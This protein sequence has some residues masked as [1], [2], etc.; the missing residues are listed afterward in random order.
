MCSRCMIFLIANAAVMFTACPELCPS[1][2]PGAPCTSG[3]V[4]R[5]ARNL[6]RLRNAIEVGAERD[7]GFAGAPSRN[8]GRGNSRHTLAH[9][10][11]VLLEDADDVLRRFE[12][13]KAQL[14][15]AE[16]LIDELLRELRARV[17][18]A[19][20]LGLERSELRAGVG[21]RAL[22]ARA[23]RHHEQQRKTGQTFG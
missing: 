21:R 15:E 22:R 13:L 5:D 7:D 18:V 9:R 4:A 10:E 19:H 1:P 20:R 12:F 6:R 14:S 2:C 17:D 11:A 3:Q 23:E 8:P 16:H